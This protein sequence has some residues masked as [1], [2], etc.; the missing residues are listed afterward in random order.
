MQLKFLGV[1]EENQRAM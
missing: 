1:Q